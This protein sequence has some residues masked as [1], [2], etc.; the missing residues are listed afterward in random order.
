MLDWS[1]KSSILNG[2]PNGSVSFNRKLQ[3]R[4]G[5]K[6]NTVRSNEIVKWG[7]LHRRCCGERCLKVFMENSPNQVVNFQETPKA[8]SSEIMSCVAS[9]KRTIKQSTTDK[10]TRRRKTAGLNVHF[11][12]GNTTAVRAIQTAGE[13]AKSNPTRGDY[14]FVVAPATL[15]LPVPLHKRSLQTRIHSCIRLLPVCNCSLET[16]SSS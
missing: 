2:A 14:Q 3:F 15:P 8:K 13:A 12:G 11:P 5:L 16:I 4:C 1:S 6:V 10:T 7:V 9:F